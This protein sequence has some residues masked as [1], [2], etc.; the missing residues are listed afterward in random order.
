M[1][2][3]LAA[4]SPPEELLESFKAWITIQANNCSQNKFRLPVANVPHALLTVVDVNQ[5]PRFSR[6]Y[7]GIVIRGLANTPE[8]STRLYFVGQLYENTIPKA[9]LCGKPCRYVR[10]FWSFRH[11]NGLV[12]L[13]NDSSVP[14]AKTF[15]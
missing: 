6:Y 1:F 4:I 9:V 12:Q 3:N 11:N 14:N 10:G 15:G 8:L 13:S 2:L 5:A 7:L